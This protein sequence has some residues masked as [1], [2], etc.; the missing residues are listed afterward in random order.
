MATRESMAESLK[1]ELKAWEREFFAANGHKPG[2]DDIRKDATIRDKYR[3]YERLRKP[4]TEAKIETKPSLA[5]PRKKT[6]PAADFALK[7]RCRNPILATP[8]KEKEVADEED[9]VEP[10]PAY[11]RCALGPTPQR[12]GQVLG[13][14]D[15]HP[16]ATPAKSIAGTPSKAAPVKDLMTPSK[17]TAATPSSKRKAS[18]LPDCTPSKRKL[19]DDEEVAKALFETPAFLRRTYSLPATKDGLYVPSPPPFKKRK[20]P[21]RS[22]SSMIQSLR[23]QEEERMDDELDVLNEMEAEAR[24][25]PVHNKPDGKTEVEMPLGPDGVVD[26]QKEPEGDQSGGKPF[27]KKGLKRQ[28]KR[29]IMRPVLHNPTKAVEVQGAEADNSADDAEDNIAKQKAKTTAQKGVKAVDKAVKKVS[30]TAH[31]NFR[32]LKIKNKNSKARGRGRF[33]RN[34]R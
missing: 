30:A 21:V 18:A 16:F 4:Q 27:K 17:S 12:D 20:G 14:F 7:E 5:T 1:T 19:E 29:A 2:K 11:I 10:T 22:L 34:R 33:G 15:I 25:E 24:G 13:I 26:A 9:E 31:A 23:K 8:R 28:T 6:R 3:E 32:A